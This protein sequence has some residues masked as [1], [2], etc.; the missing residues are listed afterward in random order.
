MLSASRLECGFD[1]AL[2]FLALE[3]NQNTAKM[4][5]TSP[6]SLTDEDVGNPFADST[7]TAQPYNYDSYTTS[8]TTTN[9]ATY[10]PKDESLAARE[11]ELRRREAELNQREET[12]RREQ[13]QL[14]QAG[15][16]PPNWPKVD[17]I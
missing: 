7:T 1:R 5:Q 12:L 14:R 8:Y 13:E 6:F 3:E 17:T 4:T 9:P 11:E 16:H 2:N 10:P 15:I